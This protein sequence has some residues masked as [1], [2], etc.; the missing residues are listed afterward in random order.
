MH[1][2]FATLMLFTL[3]SSAWA[4]DVID[5]IDQATD[6][7]SNGQ[8]Q[9]AISQLEFAAQLIRQQRGRGIQAFLPEPLDGWSAE[10]ANSSSAGAAL[11]G[12]GTAVER[13]YSDGS[14]NVTIRI[15]TDSPMMQAFM[16]MF[17]NPVIVSAQ[18]GTLQMIAGQR[19][20]VKPDGVTIVLQNTYLIQVEGSASEED[21][22]AYA[23]AVDFAGLQSFN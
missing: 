6:L 22:V 14:N 13:S 4:D 7:Y 17:S 8:T 1:R 5:A 3:A 10:D 21:Y 12:G 11:F 19:A 20:L 15:L 18:G 9:Q 16:M 2:V 23:G